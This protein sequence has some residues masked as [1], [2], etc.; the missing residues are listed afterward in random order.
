MSV[1]LCVSVSLSLSLSVCA[2]VC[3]CV[4]VCVCVPVCVSV[5]LLSS[6][7]SGGPDSVVTLG[8]AGGDRQRGSGL[9]V[10]FT[11]PKNSSHHHL[12]NRH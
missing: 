1:C 12:T 9:F 8:Q 11:K 10:F 2:S 4:C 7:S 3:V 6:L 5:L